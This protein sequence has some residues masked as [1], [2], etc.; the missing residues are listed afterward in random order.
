MLT[1]LWNVYGITLHE[2]PPAKCLN[3]LNTNRVILKSKITIQPLH[4][5]STPSTTCTVEAT[6]KRVGTA[7]SVPPTM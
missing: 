1:K 7:L 2:H 4:G 3:I 6:E 5:A